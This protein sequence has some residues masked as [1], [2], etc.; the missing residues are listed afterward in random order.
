MTITAAS[1]TGLPAGSSTRPVTVIRAAGSAAGGW[2]AIGSCAGAVAARRAPRRSI[3]SGRSSEDR[4]EEG[5]R[6]GPAAGPA[7]ASVRV[8]DR[9]QPALE[10]RRPRH[11]Q[12]GQSPRRGERGAPGR[13]PAG[14]RR[15]R[16]PGRRPAARRRRRR[17]RAR[18]AS[19]APRTRPAGGTSRPRTRPGRSHCVRQSSRRTCASSCNRTSR[20]RSTPHESASA[21]S[22]TTGRIQ[23][24]VIGMAARSPRSRVTRRDQPELRREVAQQGA[25]SRRRRSAR[26]RASI[27]AARSVRPAGPTGPRGPR[28]ARP[29]T[30]TTT[31][32]RGRAT[33]EPDARSRPADAVGRDGVRGAGPLEFALVEGDLV[34]R[35]R[36]RRRGLRGRGESAMPR[37]PD[38][39]PARRQ[40]P[41]ATS[42]A[43][44]GA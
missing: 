10:L 16:W 41:P 5:D 22:R 12:R 3:A 4:G 1:G 27:V 8:E 39:I 42:R 11:R 20:R 44:R 13:S 21:G 35:R 18:P 28:P 38:I 7:S 33:T 23:P 17:A 26:R 25:S 34:E 6:R 19:D 29:P 9:Q 2:P 24:Q 14:G 36:G 30:A 32:G 31:T 40:D 37:G 43:G 15:S